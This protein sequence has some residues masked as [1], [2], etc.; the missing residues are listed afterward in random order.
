MISEGKGAS[1]NCRAAIRSDRA[2]ISARTSTAWMCTMHASKL[3]DVVTHHWTSKP[4]LVS[5]TFSTEALLTWLDIAGEPAARTQCSSVHVFNFQSA[6]WP[7]AG[8]SCCKSVMRCGMH[9]YASAPITNVSWD[10]AA[11]RT[12]VILISIR[13]TGSAQG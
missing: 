4:A 7:Q 10:S 9:A 5:A 1:K 2:L 12:R 3:S 11:S 6:A 13:T 8:N